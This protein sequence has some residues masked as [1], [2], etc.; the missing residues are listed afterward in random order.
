MNQEYHTRDD[1]TNHDY[2]DYIF[3]QKDDKTNPKL[4]IS[5]CGRETKQNFQVPK[6]L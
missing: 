4:Y 5:P 2:I 3:K 1:K 6:F